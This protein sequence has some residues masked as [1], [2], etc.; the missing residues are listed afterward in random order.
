LSESYEL[1]H[2]AAEAAAEK[3]AIDIKI[4]DISNISIISDYFI[5]TSG[6]S[7]T[8]VQAICENIEKKLKEENIRFL[9]KEGFRKAHWVLLD[10]GDVV[11]HIFLNEKRNFYNLEDIWGDA[12]VEEY[13]Y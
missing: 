7:T 9:R 5:I 2:K 6:N 11:I 12:L 3:K 1:A 10:Y 4:L 13:P 8:Q